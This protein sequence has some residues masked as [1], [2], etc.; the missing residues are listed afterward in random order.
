M[1]GVTA[2]FGWLIRRSMELGQ[3]FGANIT[4]N[5]FYS[6]FPDLAFLKRET[7]WR[8]PWSMIGI[9]GA[10]EADAVDRQL[11]FVRSCCQPYASEL[12]AGGIHS[13][14]IARNEDGG[15]GPIEAA[16]LYCYVRATKPRKIVQIGC[17]VSTAVILAAAEA[18]QYKPEIVC[19][20]PYPTR[21]LQSAD[22]SGEIRLVHEMAQ[23]TPLRE[24]TDLAANDLLFVDST[25]TVRLGSEVPWLILEVL[26]RLTRGVRVHFHDIYFPYDYPPGVLENELFF[27]RESILLQAFLSMNSGYHVLAALSMLH[28]AAPARLKESLPEYSPAVIRD[29]RMVQKGHFPSSVYLERI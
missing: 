22:A 14:A 16:F 19:V 10:S 9:N 1:G 8:A 13:R 20:E 4:P 21:F 29:A 26:P 3:R 7:Y 18:E 24:L 27:A 23:K 25:H 15:F 2:R 6:E 12:Q 17:G 28:H 5:H 11:A